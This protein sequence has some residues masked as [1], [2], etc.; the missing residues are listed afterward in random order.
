MRWARQRWAVGLDA[1]DEDAMCDQWP[2]IDSS[3]ALFVCPQ[4]RDAEFQRCLLATVVHLN[5]DHKWPREQIADW[6]ETV[7]Q[8]A[9]SPSLAD[10]VDLPQEQI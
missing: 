7:E 3:D 6:V 8:K 4:C 5:D 10:P 1:D 9:V 2:G